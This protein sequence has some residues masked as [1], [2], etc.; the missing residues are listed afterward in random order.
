MM[1][2]APQARI[3]AALRT[4]IVPRGGAFA[5][6]EIHD[7]AAPLIPHLL[8]QAGLSADQVDEVILGNALGAG[9][10]PARLV[11]LAAGLPERV[12]G[13]SLDRQCCGGLDALRIGAALIGSGLAQVV[14]AGGAESYSRRPL[15]ARRSEDAGALEFYD[16]P[17]F[18]PWPNRDP[19]MHAAAEALAR[20][21]DL[22]REAQDAWAIKSH[23]KACDARARM[24]A[25]I[26]TLAGL[27]HDPFARPLTAR[28]A[29]R[30]RPLGDGTITSANASV[31]ADG[32][33]LVIM[34]SEA[35]AARLPQAGL[36]FLGGATLGDDPTLPG[37]APIA[38]IK[39]AL[40]AAGLRAG[41]LAVAEVMEAYAVQAMACVQGA[42]LAEEITNLGGGALARGHPIGASGA[43][44]AVR[45]F[46]ELRRLGGGIGVAAIAAAGGL[47]TA[48]LLGD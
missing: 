17:P 19:E 9:G 15:R 5:Q 21:L 14:I 46:H 45:L 16:R 43:V 48:V 30:A 47:G 10:N 12:A 13:L 1:R 37:L 23:A 4:A 18:T 7:L 33:A 28:L 32:A 25:E 39:A 31:A 34:V 44:N 22:S 20:K 6:R 41:D 24:R 36:R 38:A 27:D 26:V 42:G 3:V 29:A 40:S 11:A 8:A 2:A 35:I